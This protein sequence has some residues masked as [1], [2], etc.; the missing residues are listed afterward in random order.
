MVDIEM[1]N[2]DS[3]IKEVKLNP[4]KPLMEKGRTYESSSKMENFTL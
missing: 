3:K 2:S 4:P 1:N